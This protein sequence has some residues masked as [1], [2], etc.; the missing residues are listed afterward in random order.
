M[1][2]FTM[3]SAPFRM[4]GTQRPIWTEVEP[5]EEFTKEGIEMA[6]VHNPQ[7]DRY[8]VAEKTSGAFVGSGPTKSHAKSRVCDDI[9]K[10][11]EEVMEKQLSKHRGT[12]GSDIAEELEPEEF[13]GHNFE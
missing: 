6:V 1:K 8:H 12:I 7:N 11:D 4:G 10:A 5:V 3:K 2:V 13:W 9:E